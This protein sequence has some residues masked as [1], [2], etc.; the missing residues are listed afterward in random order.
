MYLR[1]FQSFSQFLGTAKLEVFPAKV[2]RLS[3]R[4][5]PEISVKNKTH[6]SPKCVGIFCFLFT[7]YD[8]LRMNTVPKTEK[9]TTIV[10]NSIEK[11]ISIQNPSSII[12]DHVRAK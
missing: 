5:V 6:V 4:K 10:I 12:K 1:A 7:T 3:T 2:S 9:L 11:D 8:I